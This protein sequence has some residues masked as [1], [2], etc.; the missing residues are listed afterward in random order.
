MVTI[1][2][3]E[4]FVKEV[5]KHK[6]E[7]YRYVLRTVW[8]SGAA[9]DVFAS[10]VL[11]AFENRMKFKS[12]TNF[13]AWMYRILTNKCF[14]ANREV[15]RAFEPLDEDAMTIED[16]QSVGEYASV[17]DDPEAV[18]EQCGDEVYRAFKSLSTAQ[19]SCLLLRGIE[20]FS[21]QEIAEILGIPVGTVMT[22]LSR[23][24]AKLRKELLDYARDIGV[25]KSKPR[26]WVKDDEKN[27]ERGEASQ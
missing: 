18:F 5:E 25:V 11:A 4:D 15:I 22:H 23:G 10:G 14:V 24:R 7:F 20:R 3:P 6:D 9:E 21:Y 2:D 26:L 13:R 27:L 8:D 12:G 1:S 19:R 17:L 16:V